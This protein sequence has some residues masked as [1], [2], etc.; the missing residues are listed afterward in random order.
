LD[1]GSPV[2]LS[3]GAKLTGGGYRGV[4]SE[5]R[6]DGIEVALN[7]IPDDLEDHAT[8]RL[9]IAFDE[10]A[11]HRQRPAL[12]QAAMAAGNRT[13]QLRAI[14]LGEKAPSFSPIRTIPT[15]DA[16]LNETQR[17]AVRLAVSARDIALIHG[18]PGTGKT[19]TVVEIIRHAIR[20]GQKIL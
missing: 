10:I 4:I 13:A 5:R 8:W 6:P 19:T 1:V 3:P 11:V 17:D 18:P 7:T 15:L 14:L 16:S 9:D 2:L 20:A 12:Q